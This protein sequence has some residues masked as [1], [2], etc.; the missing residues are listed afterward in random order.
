MPRFVHTADW[1]AASWLRGFVV[2]AALALL[3]ALALPATAAAQPPYFQGKTITIYVGFGPGGG[4]DAYAQ[5]LAGHLRRHIPGE[6]TVI[7][8]HMPGAGSLV[9][10][11]YLFNVA[12]RDGTAFGI[13]ASNSAFVPLIG[14]AQEQTAAKFDATKFGWL[15]SL[16][17]FAP[18][19]IA[20]H[21]RGFRTLA[22]VKLR[23]LH[24][25]SS[26][27]GSGGEIYAHMLNEMIGTKL[28]PV[29]GYRGSNEI[30]L[31]LERGELDG[32]VGWCW[33]CM[34]ADKPQYINDRLV[35]LFVQ[36][37]LE[38]EPE[39][40][41]TPFALD[42]ITHPQD[43]QAARLIL[44]NLALSRPFVAPPGLPAERLNTL[45][46][47]LAAT[48]ADPAFRAA[49]KKA[50]RDISPITGTDIDRLLRESYS[51]PAAVIKRAVELSTA[52]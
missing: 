32:F 42:L 17:R 46:D 49:A 2:G 3:T 6:P 44:A 29:R 35:N 16:E 37:G 26:G 48:A 52:R 21:S 5:L 20:W 10:M 27:A 12:P 14:S 33:T 13:P 41:D 34:K 22:D 47:G 24:F 18:I 39:M 30:T 31:A 51:L 11:N 4:Y 45:R 19:G 8:K 7:V 43:K 15:G 1:R 40:R 23:E 50:G 36:I 38:P 25:G 28:R 9:L